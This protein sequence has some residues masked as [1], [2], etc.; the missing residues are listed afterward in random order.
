VVRDG[1]VYTASTDATHVYAINDAQ[2]THRW[3][4]AVP[5]YPWQRTA[6][7][8]ELVISGSVGRGAYPASRNGACFALDRASGALRWIYMDL[9]TE[10]QAKDRVQW[11]FAAS[12]VIGDGVVYAAD[13]EGR[14]YA[15]ELD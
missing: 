10:R 14:V 2:G 4:T 7:G 15:F 9:P 8:E 13:L 11:G 1:V 5:G 3:K 6:V 12:P